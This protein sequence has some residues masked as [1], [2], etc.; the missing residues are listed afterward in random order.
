[1]KSNAGRGFLKSAFF[2][3]F[4]C[5]LAS[6]IMLLFKRDL[7]NTSFISATT[8]I[9]IVIVLLFLIV[10]FV[11]FKQISK[12][13]NSEHAKGDN[14]KELVLAFTFGISN[15]FIFASLYYIYGIQFDDGLIVE[16][17]SDSIYFSIVTWTTLG[18]GDFKPIGELRLIASLEALMG[19]IYMAILVGLF[20][21]T[22]NRG[23]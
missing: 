9:T 12:F 13:L 8:S 3:V 17:F 6:T 15:I 22:M 7:D 21:N 19:Y 16:S 10:N 14:F 1:M 4:I 5:L 18:Y 11:F 20:L 23:K 2:S